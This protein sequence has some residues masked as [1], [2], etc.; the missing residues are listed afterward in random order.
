MTGID[1]NQELLENQQ[2]KEKKERQIPVHRLGKPK[3]IA[4]V[5][6]F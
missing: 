3:E 4:K 1:M 5:A 2:K 6:Y